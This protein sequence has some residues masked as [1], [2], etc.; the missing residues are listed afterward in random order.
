M[1]NPHLEPLQVPLVKAVYVLIHAGAQDAIRWLT[2]QVQPLMDKMTH[3]DLSAAVKAIRVFWDTE[4][5]D[6]TPAGCMWRA[7]LDQAAMMPLKDSLGYRA[8]LNE[9]LQGL[10]VLLRAAE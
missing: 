2:D 3:D 1:E 4:I 9:L 8:M 10:G 5:P 7:L 6:S